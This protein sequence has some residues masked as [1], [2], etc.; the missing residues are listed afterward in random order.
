MGSNTEPARGLFL[1]ASK[2]EHATIVAVKDGSPKEV[3]PFTGEIVDV[4]TDHF[5]QIET[6]EGNTVLI[7]SDNHSHH[8]LGEVVVNRESVGYLKEYM[9]EQVR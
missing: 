8:Q 2:G 5:V 7:C 9:I 3:R 1:G 6:D 4:D